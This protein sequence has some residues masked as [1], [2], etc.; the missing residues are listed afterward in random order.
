MPRY[1]APGARLRFARRCFALTTGVAAM[2]EHSA[3]IALLLLER[4]T[5]LDCIAMKAGLTVTEVDRY[6]T[7]I[8]TTL[9]LARHDSERC[10]VCG[11]VGPAFSLLQSVN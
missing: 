6:L 3:V 4:P 7:I 9:A 1:V 11:N 5:C 2:P 10:R 8:G